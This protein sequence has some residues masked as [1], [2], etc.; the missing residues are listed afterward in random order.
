MKHHTHLTKPV[1][2][3][4]IKRDWHLVD[5]EN[6]VLGRIAGKIAQL[7]SGKRKKIFSYNLDCGDYVVVINASKI[8]LTGRKMQNKYYASYSG[9]PGGLKKYKAETL[10]KDKPDFILRHAVLGMLPSNKLK[11]KYIKRL[12]IFK[13]KDH[14]FTNKFKNIDV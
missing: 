7:L 10:F 12:Y 3:S 6:K 13:N 2:M 14:P 4:E 1:R 5:A 11:K 8:V 9:Y